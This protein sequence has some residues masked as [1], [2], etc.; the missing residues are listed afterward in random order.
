[1]EIESLAVGAFQ[2]NAW[3]VW[4]PASGRGALL[5]PGDEP[6]RIRSWVEGRGVRV[7]ILLATHGH[8][9][10]VSAA[11]GL[12][13]A[14]GGIPFAM[15]PADRFLLE[16]LAGT[17]K[18]FGLPPVDPPPLDRELAQGDKIPLGEGFLEVLHVPG[19]SPGSV[20]FL[21]GDTLFTGDLLFRGSVGRTDLPG[22]DGPLLFQSIREKVLSLPGET[23]ILPGHGPGT[24]VEE[25]KR[26]NPFLAGILD[27]D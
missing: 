26:S 25:E 24:T 1:M 7:E 21:A 27:G 12:K 20:A 5:D 11:P 18:Q 15:H 2:A 22:G 14:W 17:R 9:D 6:E 3:L 16:G 19:H 13:E 23:R 10:H 8:L 4:D